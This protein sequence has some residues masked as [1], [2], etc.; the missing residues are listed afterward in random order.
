M[1]EQRNPT[2]GK[3]RGDYNLAMPFLLQG[4]L[5]ARLFSDGNVKVLFC[6][7]YQLIKHFTAQ[8]FLF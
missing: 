1:P 8:F 4:L 5:G 6:Y 2:A 7:I 3:C